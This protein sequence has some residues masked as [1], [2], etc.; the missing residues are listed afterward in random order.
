MIQAKELQQQYS[1]AE[2]AIHQAAQRCATTSAVPMDLKDSVQQMDQQATQA[3]DAILSQDE[4]RIRQCIDD[5]EEL[6]DR[7]KSA[8]QD[9]AQVDAQLKESVMQAH[10]RLSDLKRQL[11]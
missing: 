3:R 8:C 1:Q 2:S 6:G 4:D 7:A 5:L 10:Q 11:H 9:G